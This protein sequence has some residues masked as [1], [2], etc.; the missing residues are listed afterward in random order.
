MKTRKNTQTL[1]HKDVAN[2]SVC[3]PPVQTQPAAGLSPKIIA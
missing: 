2:L 1:E 3:P